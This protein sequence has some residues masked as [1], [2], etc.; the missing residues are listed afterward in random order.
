MVYISVQYNNNNNNNVV[1]NWEDSKN[2]WV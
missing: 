2:F 1:Q